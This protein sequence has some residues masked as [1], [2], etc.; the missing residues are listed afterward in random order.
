VAHFHANHHWWLRKG[1]SMGFIYLKTTG[2]W[3]IGNF[4]LLGCWATTELE[5]RG[6]QKE[7]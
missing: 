1:F 2:F 6:I 5:A 7:D 3:E 4:C